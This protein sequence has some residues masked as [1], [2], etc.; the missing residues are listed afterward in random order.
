MAVPDKVF[1]LFFFNFIFKNIKKW[2]KLLKE[3]KDD[4]WDM[5][6][7]VWNLTNRRKDEKCIVYAESHD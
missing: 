3:F 7:L 6:D 5:E 4:E 1:I 2:I